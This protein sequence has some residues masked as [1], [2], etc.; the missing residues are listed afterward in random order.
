MT[1]INCGNAIKVLITNAYIAYKP[2]DY[3]SRP[4]AFFMHRTQKILIQL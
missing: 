4:I 2:V 1:F 3:L